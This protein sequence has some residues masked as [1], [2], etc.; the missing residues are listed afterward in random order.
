MTPRQLLD[1]AI[2]L[3]SF[4]AWPVW[5]QEAILPQG[6]PQYGRKTPPRRRKRATA[7]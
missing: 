3:C 5:G 1:C 4:Q 7:A 2:F 6:D